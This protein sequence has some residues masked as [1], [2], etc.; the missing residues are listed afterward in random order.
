MPDLAEVVGH[1]PFVVGVLIARE[2]LPFTFHYQD[3]A[4]GFLV[5]AFLNEGLGA[6]RH[7]VG[8]WKPVFSVS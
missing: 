8:V 5:L 2:L 4:N 3:G 6:V 7:A 1:T